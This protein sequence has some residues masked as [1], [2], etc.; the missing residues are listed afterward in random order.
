M[1]VFYLLSLSLF[2]SLSISPPFIHITLSIFR[3]CHPTHPPGRFALNIQRLPLHF[4][5]LSLLIPAYI[6]P[7]IFVLTT[8]PPLAH[9]I[10]FFPTLFHSLPLSVF[11]FF[12]S[13]SLASPHC[14]SFIS[15]LLPSLLSLLPSLT[16][17]LTISLF[18]PFYFRFSF[19][20]LLISLFYDL[21]FSFLISL[22]FMRTSDMKRENQIRMYL[23]VCLCVLWRYAI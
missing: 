2:P 8:S 20:I 15:I 7:P 19:F 21:L 18:P 23:C 10:S 6:L 12:L 17:L 16:I 4:S 11:S 13:L 3:L 22:Q 1:V 5:T 14:I 9:R